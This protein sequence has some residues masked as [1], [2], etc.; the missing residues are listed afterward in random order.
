MA[1]SNQNRRWL[2]VGVIALIA[3]LAC[4]LFGSIVGAGYLVYTQ[5]QE[6]EVALAP[7]ELPPDVLAQM[8]E[9]EGQVIALRGLPASGDFECLIFSP[10]ELQERVIN[11]FFADYSAEEAA[12]DALVLSIFGLL[13]A[14]Y[15]LLSLYHPDSTSPN[16]GR[17]DGN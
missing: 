9:I 3:V 6:P 12:E 8:Q 14:D 13:E 5:L 16:Q 4:V 11:D 10:A 17:K 2:P 1:V 7:G 15:D